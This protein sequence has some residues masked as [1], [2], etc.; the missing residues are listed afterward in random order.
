MLRRGCR[1]QAN[2]ASVRKTNH[3]ALGCM[4][5]RRRVVLYVIGDPFPQWHL[6]VATLRGKSPGVAPGSFRKAGSIAWAKVTDI[7]LPL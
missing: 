1:L 2:K 6:P 7:L 5:A 4:R 3:Y